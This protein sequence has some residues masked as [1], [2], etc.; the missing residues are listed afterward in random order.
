MAY[1]PRDGLENSPFRTMVR[2]DDGCVISYCSMASAVGLGVLRDGG[3]AVDAA[4]ATGLA[5]AVT[6]PQAGNLGGGGFMLIG[7]PD[8]THTALDYRETAPR[9]ASLAAYAEAESAM[10]S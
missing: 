4:V 6:Y 3:N 9:R 1:T 7:S 2:A 5:L 8:G 10:T